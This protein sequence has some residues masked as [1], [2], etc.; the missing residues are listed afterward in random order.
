MEDLSDT[1]NEIEIETST[2]KQMKVE[3]KIIFRG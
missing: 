1:A 3:P 2:L